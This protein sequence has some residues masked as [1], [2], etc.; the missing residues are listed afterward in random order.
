[1]P[2]VITVS[3]T[4]TANGRMLGKNIAELPGVPG[5]ARIE[6]EAIL[7]GN[8]LKSTENTLLYQ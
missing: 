7:T 4:S 2:A 3:S 8:W 1:M 6:A 5:C